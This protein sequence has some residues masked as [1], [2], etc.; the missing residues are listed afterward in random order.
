MKRQLEKI[1]FK[2]YAEH[3]VDIG[4]MEHSSGF[5]VGENL[6]WSAGSGGGDDQALAAV[7]NWYDEIE[8]YNFSTGQS[9]NG[10]AT[11]HFTQVKYQLTLR[12]SK[13]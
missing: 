5:G 4:K 2:S 11:G 13:L 12:C 6:Y 10:K 9:T 3:L 8:N 1:I 7:Q